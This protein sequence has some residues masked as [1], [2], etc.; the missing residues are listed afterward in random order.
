MELENLVSNAAIDEDSKLVE[1]SAQMLRRP[2]SA[3]QTRAAREW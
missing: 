3:M 1:V 2:G